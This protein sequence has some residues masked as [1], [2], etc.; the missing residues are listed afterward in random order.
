[1]GQRVAL[2]PSP[3]RRHDAVSNQ[4]QNVDAFKPLDT[5]LKCFLQRTNAARFKLYATNSHFVKKI[6]KKQSE[7]C[8]G[9]MES[10]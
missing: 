6:I 5:K 4:M 2:S 1:M 10:H 8:K 9:I 3:A 7:I